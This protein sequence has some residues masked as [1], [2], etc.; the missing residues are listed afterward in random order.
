MFPSGELHLPLLDV[1]PLPEL[2]VP[3]GQFSEQIKAAIDS[4]W[5][6]LSSPSEPLAAKPLAGVKLE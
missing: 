3:V 5:Q 2:L 4:V 1:L 6:S